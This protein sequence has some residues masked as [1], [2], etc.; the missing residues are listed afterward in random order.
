MG[1]TTRRWVWW[2]RGLGLVAVTA[3][4]ALAVQHGVASDEA[5]RRTP[6][7]REAAL[8]TA[9]EYPPGYGVGRWVGIPTSAGHDTTWST[10]DYTQPIIAASE[11]D[12]DAG[13]T[14]RLVADRVRRPPT[15]ARS[16]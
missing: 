5:D 12:G 6:K 13:H 14:A 9:G 3:V 8:L 4:I 10:T 7:E 1:R 2:A 11:A 16:A 15:T